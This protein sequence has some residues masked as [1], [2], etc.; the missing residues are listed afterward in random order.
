MKKAILIV[1]TWTE[2]QKHLV[3]T[4]KYLQI[5][6][7]DIYY[8]HANSINGVIDS[9]DR[10]AGVF[11]IDIVNLGFSK[12]K[13]FISSLNVECA[14]Y[15]STNSF[16]LQAILR[17]LYR[18]NTKTVHIYHGFNSLVNQSEY[19][20]RNFISFFISLPK[21]IYKN[22]IILSF[23]LQSLMIDKGLYKSIKYILGIIYDKIFTN[24]IHFSYEDTYTNFGIVYCKDDALHMHEKYKVDLKNIYCVGFPDLSRFDLIHVKVPELKKSKVLYISAALTDEDLVFKGHNDYLEFLLSLKS[25]LKRL[26]LDMYFKFKPHGRLSKDLAFY[27]KLLSEKIYLVDDVN[28]I[29]EVI[30][31]SFIITE[32]ST[33]SIVPC[34][35]N[36][37]LGLINLPPFNNNFG[38]FLNSYPNSFKI[39]ESA[40]LITLLHGKIDNV[41]FDSWQQENNLYLQ[42][43][44]SFGQTVFLSLM[45]IVKK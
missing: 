17:I 16:I 4:I 14:I 7:F 36:L 26:G 28:F 29:S 11:Y 33:L 24:N 25:D 42:N 34:F 18:L 20:K 32:P 39:N 21:K 23:Y 15:L 13:S 27:N 41:S 9:I 44:S 30:T 8:L 31:S 37:K 38:N 6:G 10:I 19:F 1:D 40:D 22:V 43:D 3:E 2:G 12:T 5:Q 45:E 35:F